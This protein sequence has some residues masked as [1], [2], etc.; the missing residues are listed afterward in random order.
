MNDFTTIPDYGLSWLEASGDHADIG[1]QRGEGVFFLLRFERDGMTHL[2]AEAFSRFVH[3]RDDGTDMYQV[4]F[5]GEQME[6][7]PGAT[8]GT[9]IHVFAGAKEVAL[10]DGYESDLGI[11]RFDR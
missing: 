1:L 2:H 8:M 10:L 3:R 7:A 9:E 5:L 4:D 11:A 6:I